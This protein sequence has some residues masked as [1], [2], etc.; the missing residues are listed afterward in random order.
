ML[1]AGCRRTG[2]Q[3]RRQM[4]IPAVRWAHRGWMGQPAATARGQ[5]GLP[6]NREL[7]GLPERL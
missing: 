7:L 4:E 1:A 2:R 6:D 3:S 5:S